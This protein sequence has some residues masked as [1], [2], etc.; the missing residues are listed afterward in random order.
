MERGAAARWIALAA[1]LVPVASGIL[2][3]TLA[4]A[5]VH[6]IAV[7]ASAA[8]L[9]CLAMVLVPRGEPGHGFLLTGAIICLMLLAASFA[10]PQID[11]VHRWIALGPIQLHAGLLA[12][13][14]LMVILP[15]LDR[16]LAFGIALV[17]ASL[18]TLQPDR[19]STFALLVSSIFLFACTRER[20]LL[21]TLIAAGVA[22]WITAATPDPLPPVRFVENVVRDSSAIHALLPAA[23]TL[24]IC[25]AALA[26]L[27]VPRDRRR[28]SDFAWSA[29]LIGF[30]LASLG[31][32]YPTPLLGYGASPILGFGLALLLIIASGNRTNN[33][34]GQGEKTT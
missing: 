10:G 34:I 7:N 12:L 9:V 23:L 3:M 29:C 21:A 1:F 17:A 8:T 16:W 14:L 11:S 33:A 26:P 18:V 2:L 32:N 4:G 15:Q 5:P 30:F 31:G 13:P 6:Y 20:W 28:C 19:A 25:V 27:A 22:F 24:S